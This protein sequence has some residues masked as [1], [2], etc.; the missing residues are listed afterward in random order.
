M[1][2]LDA[3]LE[4]VSRGEEVIVERRGTPVAALMSAV[5]FDAVRVLC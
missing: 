5:K 4:R 1:G 3:I 2:R